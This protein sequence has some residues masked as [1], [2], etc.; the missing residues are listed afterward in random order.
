MLYTIHDNA[1]HHSQRFKKMATVKADF[2]TRQDKARRLSTFSVFIYVLSIVALGAAI[3]AVVAATMYFGIPEDNK[4]PFE[5][6]ALDPTIAVYSFGAF[7]LVVL[8]ASFWKSRSLASG[9]ATVAEAMGGRQITKA[10][11]DYRERRLLNIVEEMSL[12]S[13][14]PMPKVFVMDD[15][16]GVNA[17]AAGYS[18]KDAAVAVTKG[19][20]DV[21]SRAELQAVIGH[22]FSHIHNG[23]MRLNIRLI[24]LLFGIL[25][26]SIIGQIAFRFAASTTRGSRGG[27]RN[28]GAGVLVF[29][30]AG[31]AIWLLGSLGVFFAR[32]IQ[33]AVSRQRENLAD[34][35]AVQFTRDPGA[36]AD[37]LKV[38]GASVNRGYLRNAETSEV[39]HML[40]AD[41]LR[42]NL[43]AT[44]PPLVKRIRA[45]EPTFDGKFDETSRKIR[46]RLDAAKRGALPPDEE[47]ES[48]V[49]KLVQFEHLDTPDTAVP[50][51]LPGVGA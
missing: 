48:F 36:M 20:L 14:V 46:I 24:S 9:G 35:S 2:F 1:F 44:H 18:P 30:L 5:K 25:C 49:E 15:E 22:E 21:F 34:A 11:M 17:F 39:A 32:M 29:V 37:A 33:A 42:M 28:G 40:F 7:F 13:G 45:I 3:H 38:I 31:A 47:E 23:D 10:T 41:G 19:A 26:I 16:E 27:G 43:F 4:I 6:V 8:F 50:P 51:P 12:A